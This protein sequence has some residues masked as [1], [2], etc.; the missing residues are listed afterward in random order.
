[1]TDPK[2]DPEVADAVL[3]ARILHLPDARAA[4]DHHVGGPISD[5][6]WDELRETWEWHFDRPIAELQGAASRG[7]N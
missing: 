7:R 6:L 4:C 1:M 2:L 5:A 3:S